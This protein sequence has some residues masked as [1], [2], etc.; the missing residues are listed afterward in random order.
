MGASV[1]LYRGI[2]KTINNQNSN[3]DEMKDKI[4]DLFIQSGFMLPGDLMEDLYE[5][6]LE[7]GIGSGS[8]DI[9]DP[10]QLREL[11]YHLVDVID[12]FDMDYDE[13][14]DP[15]VL[16]EW[17]TVKTLFS[18]YADDIDD[19]LLTYIMQFAIGKGAFQS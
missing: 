4:A 10:D 5:Y 12:L 17:V 16:D 13:N 7:S 11:A 8:K 3:I 2:E 6:Y 15:L 18:S 14:K 1:V 19:E 9:K